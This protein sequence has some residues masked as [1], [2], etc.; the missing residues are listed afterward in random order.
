M[1]VNAGT[2]AIGGGVKGTMKEVKLVGTDKNSVE[3][4]LATAVYVADV[5]ESR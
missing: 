4:L 1:T 5:D 2:A 3:T